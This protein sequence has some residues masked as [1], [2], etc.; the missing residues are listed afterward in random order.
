MRI[1]LLALAIAT[2]ICCFAQVNPPAM[3]Q[4]GS[5]GGTVGKQ[6]KSASGGEEQ[7]QPKLRRKPASAER[8]SAKRDAGCEALSGSTWAWSWRG[9]TSGDYHCHA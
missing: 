9:I 2:P 4:A 5:A 7:V 8:A 6:D 3:A 1:Q